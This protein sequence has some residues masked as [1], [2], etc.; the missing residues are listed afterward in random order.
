MVHDGNQLR[1]GRHCRERWHNH[2]NPNL[3]KGKWTDEEDQFLITQQKL[4]G[5]H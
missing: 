4:I 2:I 3:N 1:Q 5:N